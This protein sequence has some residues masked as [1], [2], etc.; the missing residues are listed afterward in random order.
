[1]L[2]IDRLHNQGFRYSFF[3]FLMCAFILFFGGVGGRGLDN[4]LF[5]FSSSETGSDS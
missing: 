1:M 5:K 4:A 2:I 3:F